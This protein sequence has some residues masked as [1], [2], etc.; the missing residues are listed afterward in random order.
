MTN[1]RLY[2]FLIIRSY[3]VRNKQNSYRAVGSTNIVTPDFNPGTGTVAGAGTETVET[4]ATEERERDTQAVGHP[5]PQK[6][7]RIY[8]NTQNLIKLHV[9][10]IQQNYGHGR[11]QRN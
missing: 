10:I 6:P 11:N 8:S 5:D 7:Y 3:S 2:M 4:G 1:C 9:L